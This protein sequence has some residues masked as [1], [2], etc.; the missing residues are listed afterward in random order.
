[1]SNEHTQGACH[2]HYE[3]GCGCQHGHAHAS[4]ANSL[5]RATL[6]RIII[7]A[8]LLGAA[9]LAGAAPAPLRLGLFAAAYLLCGADV[10]WRALGRLLRGRA[11][12][13][14]LLMSIAT[15]G[16]AAIGE[17][18]E[19]VAVML[20]Y[21]VGELFQDYALGRSRR[22]ISALLDIRPDSA[23]VQRGGRLSV[24]PAA[25]VA[26]GETI[27]IRPG[28]RVPLDAVLVEGHSALDT[29]ALTGEALPREVKP[30]D[31][32]L[33]G[34]INLSGLLTAQVSKEYGQSTA[35]RILELTEH[36]AASKAAPE[37]FITRFARYYTPAMVGLA[38][39]LALLPP[40]LLPGAQFADWL[41][42][43]LVFLVISCP[44]AL[45]ISVP[46]TFFAGLG[47][48]SRQGILIKGG[49]YLHG[50]SRAVSVFFDKTGTLTEGRFSVRQLLPAQGVSAGELLQAAAYAEHH[51]H[52]P[53]SQ[54]ICRAYDAPIDETLIEAAEEIAGQGT[55]VTVAGRRLCAGNLRLLADAGVALLETAQDEAA[56][57]GDSVVHI[58]AD[59]AYLGKILLADQLKPTAAAAVAA[60]KAAGIRHTG[61]L[62]G[63]NR[64]T[65]ERVARELGLDEACCELLP[66]DK[67]RL[68]EQRL[69]ETP[70]GRQLIYVGDGVNDAPVLARADIG[71]AMGELGADAAIEA[72][73]IVIMTDQPS[74][75]PEAIGVARR[76][77]RIVRQ[78]IVFALGI[79]L[80]MLAL[81]AFGM[82]TMWQ[83]V[84][85][86]VGVALLA[87][88]NAMRAFSTA[89]R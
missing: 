39:A 83:A 22:S 75:L 12:D 32:L 34:C 73:D 8:L 79:K 35:A 29:S 57:R 49:N 74:K 72:A 84:F 77:M 43:A 19:A 70:P 31:T 76:T 11:F 81:G 24:V 33:S 16:A 17:Y 42:R 26:A 23:T 5:D 48:A 51:S 66:A 58:A 14:N 56:E 7:S 30:G 82:A 53:L 3:H 4:G 54:S 40:L 27:V 63:D 69:A 87:V 46:L 1:M 37:Q 47:A 59:G 6:L 61:L 25:E 28:E 71:V 68:L 10:L 78:N 15:V 62:S 65:G 80:L 41:Y 89:R 44:C 88:L 13:E 38:A 36:A 50:L 60:L 21:Q 86:D 85:A 45:V 2:D 55:R 18:P 9:L 52:H 67:L 64:A 20:L